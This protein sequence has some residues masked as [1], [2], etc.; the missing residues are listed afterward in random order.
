MPPIKFVKGTG[1]SNAKLMAVSDYATREEAQKGIAFEGST[2]NLLNRWCAN[3]H[4]NSAQVYKTLYIKNFLPVP[5]SK[6]KAQQAYQ[7]VVDQFK[8]F[9]Y[10][11]ILIDEINNIDPNA[12][13]ALGERSFNFLTGKSGIHKYRGSILPISNLIEHKI[14]LPQKI[15]V[16]PALHP[17]DIFADWPKFYIAQLDINKALEQAKSSQPFKQDFLA[18]VCRDAA[19]LE[20]YIKRH[21]SAPFCITDIE[22]HL[23][24]PTAIGI[25]LSRNEALCVPILDGSIQPLELAVMFKKLNRL[26]NSGIPVVNQNLKFDTSKLERF[27]FTFKNEAGDTAIISKILYPEFQKKLDFLTSIYTNLQYYKDEGRDYDPI[28]RVKDQLYLY[29]AKDCI[30]DWRVYEE[31][32]K[33]L[34]EEG[35]YNF[36]TD[37]VWPLFHIYRK[38]DKR[39]LLVDQTK[40]EELRIKYETENAY[41]ICK[42]K[43]LTGVDLLGPKALSS[44]KVG[45]FLYKELKLPPHTHLTPQGNKAWSTDADTLEFMELNEITGSN[46]TEAKQREILRTI[47]AIR[48]LD[49][50]EEFLACYE[51]PDGRMRT[52]FDLGGTETGRTSTSKTTDSYYAIVDGRMILSPIG[53]PPKLGIPFH[54]IPKRGFLVDGEYIGRDLKSMFVPTPGYVFIAGDLSQAES[55]RVAVLAEDMEMMEMFDTPPGIHIMTAQ[56]LFPDVKIKKGTFEYDMG[57]RARHAGSYDMEVYRFSQMAHI[58]MHLAAE[59]LRKFHT[60]S[61]KI[62]NVY[63]LKV[64]NQVKQHRKMETPFGR[65][66]TFYSKVTDRTLKEGYAY[67]PQSTISDHLKFNI[68]RPLGDYFGE[69]KDVEFVMEKHDEIIVEVKESVVAEYCD[70]FMEFSETRIDC[71]LGTFPF[72]YDLHIPVELEMG[73]ENLLEMEELNY[74]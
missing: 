42:L 58:S 64:A 21:S 70:K 40:R 34:K 5:R 50:I 69:R 43:D 13:L 53:R 6:K 65:K 18:W 57:K 17:R 52:S 48:H 3:A 66:R 23:D 67:D 71:R 32:L 19:S 26:Y 45:D 56:W 39:G 61:K 8:P 68:L 28:T 33:E 74:E 73:V 16:I 20:D 37:K 55:R 7:D 12:I 41:Q 51:H 72:D 25:A 4:S 35:L 29:C 36:Y 63:H 27:G 47:V 14:R 24:I 60:K 2:G 15:K 59:L 54:T 30:S 38:I 11:N 46:E 22:L 9:S 49:K 1:P 10:D 31:Q 62:R 44:K